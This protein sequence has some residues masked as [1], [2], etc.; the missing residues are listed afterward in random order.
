M[1]TTHTHTAPHI[2]PEEIVALRR[3][4]NGQLLLQRPGRAIP[5]TVCRCFP[6]S[7]PLR[8]ISLRDTDDKEAALVRNLDDLDDESRG[9]LQQTLAE[10]GF[11]FEIEGIESI[12]EEFEI[13]TWNVRTKQGPRSFQTARDHWPLDTPSGGLIIRD[14]AGDLFH[15]AH[16]SG[17]DEQSRKVLWA[18]VD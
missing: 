1:K 14:V 16:P 5:V 17:L 3:A 15:I 7:E 18:F 6:W 11:L 10:V 13:R 12:E 4:G 9:A 2:E 8:Y